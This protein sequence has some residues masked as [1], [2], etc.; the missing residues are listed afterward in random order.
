M[1]LTKLKMHKNC[2]QVRDIV[3]LWVESQRGDM[4]KCQEKHLEFADM[5]WELHEEIDKEKIEQ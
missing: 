2:K 5:M 1:A 4:R 3:T